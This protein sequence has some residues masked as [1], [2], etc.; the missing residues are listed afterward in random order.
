M[1]IF[2]KKQA[3]QQPET[4]ETTLTAEEKAIIDARMKEVNRA[5]A[6]AAAKNAAIAGVIALGAVAIYRIAEEHYGGSDDSQPTAPT[7]SDA[8]ALCREYGMGMSDLNPD[9]YF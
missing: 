9:S 8:A 7:D 4:T 6:K 5:N 3:A 2:K 1:S